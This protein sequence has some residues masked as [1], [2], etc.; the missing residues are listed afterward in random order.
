MIDVFVSRFDDT[1]ESD[2][3]V[4]F[5]RDDSTRFAIHIEDKIDACFQ[6]NQSAR[7]HARATGEIEK[8]IYHD[9]AVVLCAPDAYCK[10]LADGGLFEAAETLRK[11]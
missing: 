8:G 10:G 3:V 4:L 11:S 9:Y 7:F 5:G 6:P 1:G 2:L